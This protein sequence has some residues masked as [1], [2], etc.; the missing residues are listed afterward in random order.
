LIGIFRASIFYTPI[1]PFH[2]PKALIALEDGAL[3]IENGRILRCGDY[4][5]VS[6]SWPGAVLHDMRGQFILPGLVDIHVH[7][8]Q[9]RI[10]GG[11]GFAL[12]D[13]LEQLSFTEVATLADAND[14]VQ[15]NSSIRSQ[16][17]VR[18]QRWS[19]V[20]TSP[21]RPRRSSTKRQSVDCES[22]PDL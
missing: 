10:L 16:H 14:A 7:F 17:T 2:E 21:L 22:R 15:A 20:P 6:A 13:W 11:L 4:S 12:L 8:P 1:N 9:I 5:Q 19:S 18:Q 3:A